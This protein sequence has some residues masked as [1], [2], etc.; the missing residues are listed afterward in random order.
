MSDIKAPMPRVYVLL[1]NMGRR[2]RRWRCCEREGGRRRTQLY[3]FWLIT[4]SPL[5]PTRTR[6]RKTVSKVLQQLGIVRQGKVRTAGVSVGSLAMGNDYPGQGSHDLFIERGLEFVE[7]CRA[8]RNCYGALDAEYGRLMDAV[9]TPRVHEAISGRSCMVFS[10]GTT[11]APRGEAVC[12]YA[13]RQEVLEALQAS[14]FVPGWSAAG[15]AT[16]EYRG[17][18]AFDGV[19]SQLQPCPPNVTFCIKVSVLPPLLLNGGAAGTAAGR[20]LRGLAD[21]RALAATLRTAYGSLRGWLGPRPWA[22]LR[23]AWRDGFL[24]KLDLAAWARVIAAN[25]RLAAGGVADI[26]PGKHGPSPL[27]AAQWFLYMLTP[28]DEA[29]VRLMYKAGQDDG[30]AW[31]RAVGWPV[32]GGDVIA[33][34]AA[35]SGDAAGPTGSRQQQQQQ[36]KQKQEAGLMTEAERDAA[37]AVAEATMAAAAEA[38]AAS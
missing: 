25:D 35:G 18:P 4:V 16:K 20:L 3:V 31:A 23:D 27:S 32:D 13:S 8:H 11:A 38:V 12:E 2:R 28:P 17:A 1:P 10:R 21:W 29:T 37:E 34:A 26:Y 5:I 6:A 24:G 14:G 19:F 7:F 15:A 33:T 22:A 30:R 36:Q 9:L